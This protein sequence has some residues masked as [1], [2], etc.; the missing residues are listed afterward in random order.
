VR[1][2]VD[3]PEELVREAQQ[4]S[5]LRTKRGVIIAALQEFVRRRRLERLRARL[6]QT[7]LALTQEDL[8]RLRA[9]D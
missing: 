2:T 5:G 1:S 9:E 7:D 3:L 8:E 6:G 4:L